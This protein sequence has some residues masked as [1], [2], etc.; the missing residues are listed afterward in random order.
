MIAERI[1]T[2]RKA[3]PENSAALVTN[4]ADC[5]YLSGFNKSEGM[6]LITKNIA[7]LFVVGT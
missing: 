1:Q 5:Y 2:I 6:V 3:L 4:E 7:C